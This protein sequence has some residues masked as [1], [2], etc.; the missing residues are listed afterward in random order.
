MVPRFTIFVKYFFQACSLPL[1]AWPGHRAQLTLAYYRE[2]PGPCALFPPAG[3]AHQG[4]NKAQLFIW[5]F[6]WQ[7]QPNMR[8]FF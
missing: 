1:A 8:N 4:S 3:C 5:D 7:S 6:I 2:G